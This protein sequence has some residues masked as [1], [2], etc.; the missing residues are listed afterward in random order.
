MPLIPCRW[1][2]DLMDT[3]L[4]GKL[5][6]AAKTKTREFWIGLSIFVFCL[7]V[8]MIY[9]MLLTEPGR[10]HV[11]D[12]CHYIQAGLFLTIAIEHALG[13]ASCPPANLGQMLLLDGFGMPFCAAIAALLSA[14][15]M[16]ALA[17]IFVQSTVIALTAVTTYACALKMKIG[18]AWSAAAGLLWSLY[19][20]AIVSAGTFL[21]EPLSG[22]LV[23]ALALAAISCWQEPRPKCWCAFG[24]VSGAIMVTKPALLINLALVLL[25][26]AIGLRLRLLAL[27]RQVF[28]QLS[29]YA[30]SIGLGAFLAILP[31]MIITAAFTG[32][33]E[34]M[35]SRLPSTNMALGC[36]Y[37]IGFWE[38][39]PVPPLTLHN[40]ARNPIRVFYE[41]ATEHTF[42]MPAILSK[43]FARLYFAP[44]NDFHDSVFG[45][46]FAFQRLLHSL[47]LVLA[48]SGIL[49]IL[50][51]QKASADEKFGIALVAANL[52]THCCYMPFESLPRYAFSAMPLLFIAAICMVR[53]CAINR[54]QNTIK[55]SI[56]F[57]IAALALAVACAEVQFDDVETIEYVLNQDETAKRETR[58]IKSSAINSSDK[59]AWVALITDADLRK[60]NCKIK[61]NGQEIEVKA[62]D[63]RSYPS[64]FRYQATID[65][66]QN[67]LSRISKVDV[68]K[69]AHYS[70]IALPIELLK[71]DQANTIEV[72]AQAPL[73]IFGQKLQAEKEFRL[74]PALRYFSVTKMFASE[75][76][77]D[78]RAPDHRIVLASKS[79]N[80]ARGKELAADEDLRLF[81]LVSPQ[82][83]PVIDAQAGHASS[84]L[85]LW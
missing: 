63:L 36:D 37:E 43:K 1:R 80:A 27:G 14:N 79:S 56:V 76:G 7:S 68:E 42:E 67:L 40:Y 64:G 84:T 16:T 17:L 38:T 23:C 52:A 75:S 69:L 65:D 34:I 6:V 82:P 32:H 11:F 78:G 29:I 74:I 9:N 5:E 41:L 51:S 62:Q 35:P 85:R 66:I 25:I 72:A 53:K 4:A 46:N 30:L 44:F 19:P 13:A 61:F 20:A 71:S 12:S 26:L 21:S 60:E 18:L 50:A 24:F 33:A 28:K 47:L 58:E 83:N 81:L 15:K 59:P 2:M 70:V 54:N 57:A 49:A 73:T 77:L 48:L 45:I 22:L 8:D 39:M 10:L 55:N 31:W 3:F